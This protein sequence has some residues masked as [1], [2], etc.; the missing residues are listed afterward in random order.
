MILFSRD[1]SH[2]EAHIV[3]YQFPNGQD[4]WLLVSTRISTPHGNGTSVDP[5]W[6]TAEVRRMIAW[7]SA[8]TKSASVFDWGGACLEANLEFELVGATPDTVTIRANFILER[9][10]W[11]PADGSPDIPDYGG[12]VD[13]EVARSS[14][15]RVAHELAD[16]LRRFP[17]RKPERRLPSPLL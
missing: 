12:H 8:M 7:F 2:V 13:L 16:E 3:G 17:P 4:N 6:Q 14:L 5:C 9:G 1:G 11:H 10:I 15:Q